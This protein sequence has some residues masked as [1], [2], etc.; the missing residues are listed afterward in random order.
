[1][2]G[3]EDEMEASAQREKDLLTIRGHHL[4]DML[5]A[6]ALAKLWV[7]WDLRKHK[8]KGAIREVLADKDTLAFRAYYRE[9]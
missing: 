7:R 9:A 5:K 3:Q 6:L 8:R 2:I 1:M 4:F